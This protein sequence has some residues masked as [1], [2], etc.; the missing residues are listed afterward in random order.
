MGNKLV[1]KYPLPIDNSVE[2]KWKVNLLIIL[3]N[4]DSL[5]FYIYEIIIFE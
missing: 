4:V 2:I 3:N 1:C 5:L